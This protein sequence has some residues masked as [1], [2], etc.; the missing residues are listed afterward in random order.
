MTKYNL[1][2]VPSVIHPISKPLSYYPIRSVF[3]PQQRYEQ[4]LTQIDSIRKKV[5]DSY[6]V[7]IEASNNIPSEWHMELRSKVDL[8]VDASM[9]PHVREATDS[10]AKGYGEAVQLLSYLDSDYFKHMRNNCI[11]VSKFTGRIRMSD[12]FVFDVPSFPRIRLETPNS[13][14]TV[15]YTLP[16][17]DVDDY[18]QALRTCTL[19]PDFTS[20]QHHASIEHKLFQIWLENKKYEVVDKFGVEGYCAPFGTLYH[21]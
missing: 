15:I 16:T 8:F 7:L 20:G 2:I 3:T 12:T 4:T 18:I 11:T 1:F 5:P 14:S 21:I 13:M 10:V 9:D 17:C 19:D 6:I